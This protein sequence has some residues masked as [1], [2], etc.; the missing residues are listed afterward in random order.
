MIVD[1]SLT[2]PEISVAALVAVASWTL[3]QPLMQPGMLMWPWF[4]I[5]ERLPQWIAKPLGYCSL[6]FAGQAALWLWVGMEWQGRFTGIFYIKGALFVLL[7]VFFTKI[8]DNHVR[9]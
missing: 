7:T 6:C 4:R 8:I 3:T 1:V 9:T 2:F 5:I